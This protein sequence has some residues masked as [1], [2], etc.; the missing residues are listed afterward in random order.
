MKAKELVLEGPPVRAL[1]GLAGP[2]IGQEALHTAFHIV[3]VAWVGFLGAWATGAIMTSMFSLW[4]AFSLANLVMIGL[5]AHVSR[6]V[7]AGDRARAGHV[8]AQAIWLTLALSVAVMIFGYLGAGWLFQL[9]GTEPRASAAGTAYL[10][11]IALGT[12]LAFIILTAGSVMRA[13]GNTL[14]PM[15]ITGGAVVGNIALAP[16]FIFGIGPFPR[17]EVAGSAIATLICQAGAVVAYLVLIA[18]RHP[19]LPIHAPSLRSL[20]LPT[21]RSLVGVGAPYAAI[22]ILFSGVYLWY[23]H[24]AAFFGDAAV[25]L[26]GIGNRLESITYLTGDGFAVATSAF[27]GQNLG[28]KNLRRAERGAWSA[29]GIMSVIGGALGLIMLALPGPLIYIF[30]RDPEVLR[31]G[32]PFL[33]IIALCQLAT[34][35]EGAIGG[36]F[37]GAGNT[38]PPMVIHVAFAVARIPLAWWAVFGLG[39][40]VAGIAWTMSLTCVIRA[41][42]LALWFRR[43]TWKHTQ[44]PG[45]RRPLPSPE[46]PEPTGI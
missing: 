41:A 4:I 42:I 18:R 14:T 28:A 29:V 38:V 6:A 27:V 33:R 13:C 26:L 39:L 22:G 21:L 19:D 1:L 34:G 20:D 43:G 15:L 9:V 23:A 44:L 10:R 25:A 45:A 30:T 2:V 37:A 12:P 24:I 3:D 17:L 5:G 36:G 7:G 40:G 32:A 46:E 8:T 16:F 11:I 31:I 35:L